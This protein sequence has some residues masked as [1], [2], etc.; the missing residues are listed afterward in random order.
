MVCASVEMTHW[1]GVCARRGG[2]RGR[3]RGPMLHLLGQ[4]VAPFTKCPEVP[5]AAAS[6]LQGLVCAVA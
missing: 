4:E 5:L 2:E 3:S 1:A 6:V